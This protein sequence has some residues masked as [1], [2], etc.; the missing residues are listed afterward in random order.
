MGI[1]MMLCGFGCWALAAWAM[2]IAISDIQIQ[3][4][5]T[6]GIGGVLCFGV[7]YAAATA[8]EILKRLKRERD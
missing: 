3:I 2:Y 4:A 5:V 8:D 7:G 1:F 6:A